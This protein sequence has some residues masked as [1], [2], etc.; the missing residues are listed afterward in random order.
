VF[1]DPERSCRGVTRALTGDAA[2]AAYQEALARI[3]VSANVHASAFYE[4]IGFDT[5]G[6]AIR[7]SDPRR[8]C[9]LV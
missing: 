6:L 3:E 1:V 2:V 8:A 4:E 5:D 7:R 9:T